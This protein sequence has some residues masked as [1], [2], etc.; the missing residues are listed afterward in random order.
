MKPLKFLL[1][2]AFV[3]T[4]TGFTSNKFKSPVNTAFK[5]GETLKYVLFYGLMNGGE[6]VMSVEEK[7]LDGKPVMHA[8]AMAYTT[9]LADRLFKIF[10]VYE[11]Y[12]DP[13][14]GLPY[15]AVRN[16]SEGRYKFY[17][18]VTYDRERDVV[19][20]K[21]KGEQEV[22]PGIEDMV[23]GF[24]NL[25]RILSE[26]RPEKNEIIE[27]TTYFSDEVYPLKI[28]YRGTEVIK[29]KMGK[30]NAMIFAPVTEPG[31]LFKTEEDILI[32]V[33]DDGN[34]LPLRIRVNFI[35][36]SL[37]CDLVEYSGLTNPLKTTR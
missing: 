15:K 24:Y 4:L 10:D 29:T 31:R 6:A 35:L 17:D 25:R 2:T 36:G 20:S 28:R 21:R 33:S 11:S 27:F 37:K 5:S 34:F 32:W 9:G 3:F 1:L 30:F 12:M 7:E 8:V 19:H 23:S 18:E 16:I 26:R 13:V 14:T 22:P